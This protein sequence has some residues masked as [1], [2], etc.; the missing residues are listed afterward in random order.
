MLSRFMVRFV[1]WVACC[2][3]GVWLG[4]GS[5]PG[6]AQDGAALTE[7]F[8]A[9]QS[10]FEAGR[11]EAARRHFR[12]IVEANPAL[13]LHVSGAAAWWLGRSHAA[14]GD[15]ADAHSA[16][17]AGVSALDA[18]GAF[19]IRLLDA[20]IRSVFARRLQREYD[21]AALLYLRLIEEAGSNLHA[22]DPAVVQRHVAQALP[23]LPGEKHAR[24]TPDSKAF[25]RGNGRLTDSAG[26]WLTGWWRRQDPLPATKR[27]ERIIEHLQRVQ[28]AERRYAT[29]RTAAGFDDR[30]R[31]Y[32]RLGAPSR[33]IRLDNEAIEEDGLGAFADLT[34]AIATVPKNS[35]WAYDE[36]GEYAVFLFVKQGRHFALGTVRDLLPIEIRGPG[37]NDS[38]IGIERAFLA[39]KVLRDYYEQLVRVRPEYLNLLTRIDAF[40]LRISDL[41]GKLKGDDSGMIDP[42]IDISPADIRLFAGRSVTEVRRA[43]RHFAR[44]RAEEVPAVHTSTVDTGNQL[45][46]ATRT[47]RFLDG[48]GITRT[49]VYWAV[50]PA[51]LAPSPVDRFRLVQQGILDPERYL[52]RLTSVRYGLDDASRSVS[53]TDYRVDARRA[54]PA[55]YSLMLSGDRDRYHLAL[56]WDQYVISP[57]STAALVRRGTIRADS[58]QTLPSDAGRLVLS[59]VVPLRADRLTEVQQVRDE[60][61]FHV[62][63]YPHGHVT[64]ETKLALYVEAYHLAFGAD[65][66]TRY[67]VEYRVERRVKQ[68]GIAGWFGGEEDKVT[69][70][71]TTYQGTTRT[72]QEYIALDLSPYA[73]ASQLRITVRV[74]DEVTGASGDRTVRFDVAR[75]ENRSAHSAGR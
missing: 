16:W 14:L 53:R 45:P 28:V 57:D 55:V 4:V 74:T 21:T 52:L 25:Q 31:I 63:P 13:R 20:Y 26:S 60:K 3:V 70:Q 19:D 58:L 56:Q 33:V 6:W 38:T 29:E 46:V 59:D 34:L 68:G 42:Q 27:N 17:R 64:P 24:V 7:Q 9:G 2:V 67:T 62:A 73:E 66:R 48:D 41:N 39:L 18:A 75:D 49:E 51:D 30:G 11:Y 44:R 40:L 72:A 61:G 23:V 10:A 54:E 37:Y 1:R 5:A 8:E 35:L 22:A 36:L 69:T 32:V 65:D 15:S 43:D 47:A 12:A 50:D 71:A